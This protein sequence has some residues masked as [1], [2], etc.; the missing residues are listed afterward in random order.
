VVVVEVILQI[1]IQVV[2]QELEDIEIH[3]QQNHQVVEEVVKQV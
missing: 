1:L 3:F 2:V